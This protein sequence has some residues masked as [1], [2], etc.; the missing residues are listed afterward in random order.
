MTLGAF[1]CQFDYYTE[2]VY[3]GFVQNITLS[4]DKDLIE[5]ARLR[6]AREKTTLN[7]AFRDW[8]DRYAG[9]ETGSSGVRAANEAVEPCAQF[10]ALFAR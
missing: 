5:R 8:L 1:A 10:A 2:T 7:A 6:A 9:R 4:A 3:T